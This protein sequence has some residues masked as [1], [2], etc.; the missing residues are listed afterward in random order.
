MPLKTDKN[1]VF[2][3]LGGIRSRYAMKSAHEAGLNRSALFSKAFFTDHCIQR[4]GYANLLK[5]LA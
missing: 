5:R 1:I 3:C 2:S 4:V